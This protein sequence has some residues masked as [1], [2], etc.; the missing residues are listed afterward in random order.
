MILKVKYDKIKSNQG[1]H[2]MK[3]KDSKQIRKQLEEEY[4]ENCSKIYDLN[5]K[6]EILK[7][8]NFETKVSGVLLFS[9]ISWTGSFGDEENAPDDPGAYGCVFSRTSGDTAKLCSRI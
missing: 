4:N 7:E 9:V 8:N 1:G 3:I 2:F 6:I 5:K